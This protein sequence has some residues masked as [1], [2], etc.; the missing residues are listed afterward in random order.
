MCSGCQYKSLHIVLP[1]GV[2][3]LKGLTGQVAGSVDVV[4]GL[5][6]LCKI[7]NLDGDL[8]KLTNVLFILLHSDE[9]L[10]NGC[11]E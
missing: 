8:S 2:K 4:S 9:L 6:S 10:L 11:Y 7:G 3:E 1:L 5:I